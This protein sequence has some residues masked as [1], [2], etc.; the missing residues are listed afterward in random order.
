MRE[1]VSV[2]DLQTILES[3]SDYVGRTR[4]PD[5]LTEFVRQR[6][7]RTIT[8]KY[9][10]ADGSLRFLSLAPETEDLVLRSLQ[11]TESGGAPTLALEP[12]LARRLVVRIREQWE[13]HQSGGT[14]VLLAPPLARAPLRR[15]IE[16]TLP[17]LAVVSSA[18]LLPT[19]H[20]E[21]IGTVDIRS[22]ERTRA[23]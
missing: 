1:G 19:V 9:T 16:R 5:V 13:L 17:R 7:A 15:L 18:E 20:I 21:R 23:A 3:L 12:E 22:P 2:R 10:A 6:L 8:R 4:D 11:A 14:F